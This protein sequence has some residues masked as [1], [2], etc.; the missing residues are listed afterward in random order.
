M[1][2]KDYAFSGKIML[3]AIVVLFIVIVIML[4]LHVYVRWRLVNARRRQHLRRS[5]RPRFVFYMDPAAR[6]ALT[7]RGLHPSV[8]STLPVF[9]FSAANNPT[10]CAVCLSEF[11][12]GETGRV[13][14]KC[15]HSFHTECIDVW[16]QSH[17]T[18]PLCRETV[19]AMPERETRSEVAVIV[20]ETEPVREEVN[21]SGPVG[22]S[23]SAAATSLHIETLG[24]EDGCESESSFRSPVSRILSFKR[25]LSR[26]KKGSVVGVCSSMTE[27]DVEQRGECDSVS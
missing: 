8:I 26:E 13:L 22:A 17:A 20:C 2:S 3:I 7:R 25:I 1:E 24:C 6:I 18:C 23:S 10:E 4:C 21:R 12:N 16:F 5:N 27:L 15:N 11:E 9:T 14:P 19:E